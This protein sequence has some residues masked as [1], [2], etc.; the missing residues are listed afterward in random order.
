MAS[1]YK[2]LTYVARF[3]HA[4]KFPNNSLK[5]INNHDLYKLSHKKPVSCKIAHDSILTWS[6]FY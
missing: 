1:D 3:T 4:K 6:P 5:E 2:M